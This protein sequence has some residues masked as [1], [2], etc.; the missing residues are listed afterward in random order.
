MSW[1]CKNTLFLPESLSSQKQNR[2]IKQNKE[3]D[4]DMHNMNNI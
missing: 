3:E 2:Q 4:T 1:Q